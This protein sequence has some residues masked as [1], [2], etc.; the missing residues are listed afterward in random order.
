MK[1]TTSNPGK[2]RELRHETATS[3]EVEH[4]YWN[5]ILSALVDG[6]TEMWL[7]V[8][9]FQGLTGYLALRLATVY[10]RGEY[11]WRAATVV[12]LCS[13][14]GCNMTVG[15]ELHRFWV[16]NQR[17][18]PG[19]G[20]ESSTTSDA[21][22]DGD[23]VWKP[24]LRRIAFLGAMYTWMLVPLVVLIVKARSQ[25][26]W[27]A[28]GHWPYTL[29]VLAIYLVLRVIRESAQRVRDGRVPWLTL[30]FGLSAT[31][32]FCAWITYSLGW[33]VCTRLTQPPLLPEAHAIQR[34]RK[35]DLHETV[36][37]NTN[38]ERPNWEKSGKLIRVAVLLSGGGY[39]AAITHAGVL[40]ALDRQHV[41]ISY[42]STVSGG[43]IIGA[44]YALGVTPPRF[45]NYLHSAKPGLINDAV[46][47]QAALREWIDATNG[48]AETYT[49]H[50]RRVFF[51][52][53]TLARLPDY[54]VLLVN[55]T[56]L[57][58]SSANARETFFKGRAP[59]LHRPDGKSLDEGT[60]IADVVAASG[61]F[62]GPFQP[63]RIWWPDA[64]NGS[65]LKERKFV[66]GGIVENLGIQ[67]LL[68]YLTLNRTSGEPPMRPDILIIS[69]A[70]LRGE[71]R[72]YPSKI[73][74]Q[75]LLSRT[76][77]LTYDVLHRYLYPRITGQSDFW[78]WMASEKPGLQVCRVNYSQIDGRLSTGK[79]KELAIVVIPVTAPETHD[80]LR[81]YTKC[82]F[83]DRTPIAEVQQ[84]VR[85]F[86]TLRELNPEEI[87]MGYWLG[88]ALGSIY[89]EAI[90]RARFG[91]QDPTGA[92][93]SK[94][95]ADDSFTCPPYKALVPNDN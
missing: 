80:L 18:K 90:D 39:R 20:S 51:G 87:E 70:S 58:A 37:T 77:G 25:G 56:D 64:E 60:L 47:V 15:Y 4:R 71:P 30:V 3:S 69:D 31:P 83:N 62:P 41:P 28:W 86:D 82:T 50:F 89:S 35:A 94:F 26:E 92:Y 45:A 49:D 78:T 21:S 10:G 12:Y 6:A 91:I 13:V 24:G 76:S 57:E 16:L 61:A 32:F 9:Y 79:P 48:T 2:A 93:T 42:L 68:Q 74:L 66:D 59:S 73:D 27:L 40:A 11:V 5:F 52:D 38:P 1:E 46:T 84:H 63:K 34:S 54:P 23:F 33:F 67:G 43:S 65:T 75:S 8:I 19:L 22:R 53:A 14:V 36:T 95:V 44:S 88:Y 29:V 17:K 72:Q 55:A 81:R 7:T 85:S